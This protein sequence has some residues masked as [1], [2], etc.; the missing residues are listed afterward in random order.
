MHEFFIGF[1]GFPLDSFCVMGNEHVL[2]K[3]VQFIQVEIGE[4]RA[5]N[6]TL[7]S[8]TVGLIPSPVFQISCPEESTDEAKKPFIFDGFSQD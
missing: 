2:D 5:D 7:G 3:L 6:R 1:V 4:D 8:T